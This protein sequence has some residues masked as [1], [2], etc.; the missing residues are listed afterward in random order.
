MHTVGRLT[1]SGRVERRRPQR[2]R[3]ERSSLSGFP[4]FVAGESKAFPGLMAV[5]RDFKIKEQIL[6]KIANL[7]NI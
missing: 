4:R 3:S 6:Y 7:T 2:R 1:A 5:L